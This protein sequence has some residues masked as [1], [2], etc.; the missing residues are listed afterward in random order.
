MLSK[1]NTAQL[2]FN[3]CTCRASGVV[4]DASDLSNRVNDG[5]RLV[6]ELVQR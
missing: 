2:P 3:V 1:P 4:S 6:E 5:A